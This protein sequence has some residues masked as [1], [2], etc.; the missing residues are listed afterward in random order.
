M[1]EDHVVRMYNP[2]AGRNRKAV[3]NANYTAVTTDQI[4]AFT[5]LSASRTVTLP[6]IAD[7]VSRAI[8]IK[9]ESGSCSPTV[10]IV[11]TP[12]SGT[13]DGASSLTLRS[14]YAQVT[15]YSNGTNW[16]T[17][18]GAPSTVDTQVFTSSGTWTKPA[19]AKMVDIIMIAP[20][21]GGGS[22]RRG[23]AGTIRC[24]GGGGS[25]GGY[26][27]VSVPAAALPATVSVTVPAQ[28]L[29]GA[30]VSTNDTNGVAAGTVAACTFGLYV[31]T[32]TNLFRAD[33][34]TATTGTGGTAGLGT[35]SGNAGGSA[36]NTGTTGL[37]GSGGAT[38][39]GAAAGGG[40]GGGS[41]TA[42]DVAG[43]GGTGG[44]ITVTTSQTQTGGVVGG[45]T[46]AA[47][48]S[49]PSGSALPGH[50]GG[51]GAASTTAAAQAGADGG[52][53]GAGGGGG[54]A[55][56]NGFASGKGGDGGPAIAVITTYF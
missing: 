47:A 5:S 13:I 44:N 32:G 35:F 33:G 14:P 46:P 17:S 1:S 45:A 38:G 28:S 8:T 10:T 34:G 36:A 55:S 56:L 30:A 24:G 53:Y 23:A 19:G 51:G 22:G 48:L 41:I 29:G 40:G 3:A 6:A 4:V 15:V 16:Y 27:R 50:G 12:A 18:V 54:G 31:R 37:G 42:A 9:D 7:A 21:S 52:W 11:V 2:Y 49:Q 43:N 39:S 26:S 20:G 25:S